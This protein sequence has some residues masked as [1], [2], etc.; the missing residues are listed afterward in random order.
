MNVGKMI[1]MR[2]LVCLFS[3][4]LM[5][6]SFF[7][8]QAKDFRPRVFVLTDISNEPDD[9]ESLVRFL[10]YANE[11]RVEGLAATTSCWLWRG[12]REDLIHKQ[13]DAYKKVY[14]NLIRH[15]VGY[16]DVEDLRKVTCTGQPEY[17]MANVG[18]EH[19]SEGSDL[20]LQA[21][22]K[23]DEGPLWILVWGGANT[24]AQ[25]L[26]DARREMPEMELNNMLSRM[27][28]YA[29][30][31]QDDAGIWIRNEFPDL[32]YIVDPSR[33]DYQSYDK[34][35]WSGISGD[36]FYQTGVGYCLGLVENPWLEK[37]IISGHG[38][39][40]ACYPRL[41]YIMEGDTP[42]FLGLVNNG[43]GWLES[44]SYGGWGGRY[45]YYQPHGESRAI[46]TSNRDSRDSF[47]YEPG[48]KHVSNQASLWRWRREYQHD[49]AA[50]MDWCITENYK[51]ANHN[52]IAVVNGND[53]KDILFV[54]ACSNNKIFLS[55]KGTTD[56]DNDIVK[57]NW[58]IYQEAGNIQNA[59]LCPHGD[60]VVVDLSEVEG[61]DKLHVIMQ[62]TDEGTPSLTSY[63]R[64]IISL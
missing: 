2:R 5:W 41:K 27:K 55:S 14:P 42:S 23:K 40:G 46:W 61:G 36:R 54:T 43:L 64:I 31:D 59:R 8:C 63:R 1:N 34:A 6:I 51:Q 33:P 20:L 29:I 39:L 22:L 24:L 7:P 35:L 10:L 16:P 37:N 44:P 52:P 57:V 9:E 26:Y 38:P 30:S 12:T 4:G 13:L 3:L 48:K 18:E 56:P 15:A 49:F 50:R 47:E 21:A 32:F 11:F 53:S 19:T 60:D 45:V 25:A 28:V 58:W 62:V 17:G